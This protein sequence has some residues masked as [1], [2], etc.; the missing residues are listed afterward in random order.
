VGEVEGADA[1]VWTDAVDPKG[2]AAALAR[3]SAR[4]VQLPLAGVE[5]F[6]AVMD[7]DRVWTSAKGIY[8]PAC[9]E[10]AL[11]LMLAA[12]RLLHR[13]LRTARWQPPAK[14]SRHRRLAGGRAVIVGTGGIGAALL[15]LLPPFGVAATAVNRSR[16]PAEYAAE[17]VPVSAL[18]QVLPEADW[19]VL[20]LALTPQTRGLFD[21]A[22]LGRMN[23][24]A[25]LVNVARG[26]L[27]DT[28][29]LVEALRSGRLGGAA[30]DVTEPE[31]LPDD[32]P[33]WSLDDV[34]ITSHSAGTE[35]M[36]LPELAARVQRN[37]ERFARGLPLEGVVDPS[38][39][40]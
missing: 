40:Y 11:A 4:W 34:I 14:G 2:L 9:A 28:E 17:T 26:A 21:A 37:V 12:S 24:D 27:V 7:R 22:M 18:P 23:P 33:L 3:S 19:V 38:L 20:A 35:A 36:A 8:G 13:H 6:V 5:E 1:L 32:H 30:L 31:P 15:R 16:L 10:H 29:A 39:G 25:W